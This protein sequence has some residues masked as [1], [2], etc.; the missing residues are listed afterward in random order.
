VQLLRAG[1]RKRR[2][3]A[4]GTVV[5]VLAIGTGAWVLTRSSTSTSAAAT[6]TSTLV[7]VS[8]ST[9]RQT[10][11]ASGTISPATEADLSFPVSGTVTSVPVSVGSKV[12]KG[13]TLA[14]VGTA[15]LAV[16]VTSA[17]AS[18][19]AAQEAVTVAAETSATQL[20]AANAQLTAASAKLVSARQDLADA[21]LTSTIDGTVA[22]VSIATGDEV[23]SSSSGG[24]ASSS[25]SAAGSGTG[26]G[27]GS[28]ASTSSSSSSTAQVVV[29]S[30]G[31][32]VVGSS[33]S[34]ADLAQ[35]KKGLQATITPS[36]TTQT[37]F[38]VVTSVGI[39][40][41][42]STSG[43]ASFPVAIAITGSPTGLYSGGSAEVTIIVKQ[44]ANALTVPT[45]AVHTVSGATVVYQ[46]VG[47]KQVNTK[48][49]VGTVS[50]QNTQILTGLK[51][52]DQVVVTGFGGPGGG[53]RPQGGTRSGTTGQQGGFGGGGN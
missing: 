12:S 43:S 44:V 42:S 8:T 45:S 7:T 41:S 28:A 27:T 25:G 21:T 14:T 22:S 13:Q 52:G 24:G 47:G 46:R 38:G 3:L 40:A 39:V 18:V 29:I 48:V 33:V 53:T 31:H 1:S 2:L 26:S 32:W 19:T 49:T 15:E 6:T 16:A 34:S 23:S 9:L 37:V 4:S 50:G 20:A 35:V 36:D 51:S 10:V 30:T 5:A 17:R 11:T